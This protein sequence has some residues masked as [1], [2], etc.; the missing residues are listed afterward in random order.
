[1][2]VVIITVIV[3]VVFVAGIVVLNRYVNNSSGRLLD[4]VEKLH[5]LA[6]NNRWS[7]LR[8]QLT[9]FKKGWDSTKMRWQLF[10]GHHEMDTID[11]VISRLEQYLEVEDKA[12]ILGQTA[13]LRLL[14]DHIKSKE[15]FMLGNV[16]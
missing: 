4:G 14:I 7:D 10:L 16:L 8:E 6:E 11:I 12:L 13:E 9:S 5:T 1:M 3:L 2:R 15:G